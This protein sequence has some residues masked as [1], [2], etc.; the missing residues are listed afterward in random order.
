[1]EI[2]LD[3]NIQIHNISEADL[4][5]EEDNVLQSKL[6][7]ST[8]ETAAAIALTQMQDTSTA[9]KIVPR[10]SSNA[11]QCG[12]SKGRKSLNGVLCNM[13][14]QQIIHSFTCTCVKEYVFFFVSFQI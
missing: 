3:C 6:D 2:C 11:Q 12:L 7:K 9:H 13:F 5:D 1:M 4:L 14:L 8:D 10:F